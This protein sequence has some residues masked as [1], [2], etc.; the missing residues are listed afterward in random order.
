MQM[1]MV[2]AAIA[3]GGRLMTPYVV[4]PVRSADLTTVIRD[5]ADALLDGRLARPRPRR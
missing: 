3:N 1:A 4:R 5:Q 2:S